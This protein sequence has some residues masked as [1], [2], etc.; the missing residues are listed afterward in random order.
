MV[1]SLI[2]IWSHYDFK[3]KESKIIKEFLNKWIEEYG[4][5]HR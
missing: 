3:S 4:N 1:N 2:K 5:E